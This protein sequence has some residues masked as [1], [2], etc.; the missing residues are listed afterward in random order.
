[1]A[2]MFPQCATM[3]N[4]RAETVARAFVG[5]VVT[6]HGVPVEC[7]SDQGTQ[8]TLFSE[9]SRILGIEQKLA[10]PHHPAAQGLVE[11]FNHTLCSLLKAFVARN[12]R[13]W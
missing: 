3:R 1:M 11:R 7:Q 10:V 2:R 4:I 5:L 8:F 9:V 13:D 6:R 12:Q